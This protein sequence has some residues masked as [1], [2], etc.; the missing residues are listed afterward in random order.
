MKRILGEDSNVGVMGY[1]GKDAFSQFF[2]DG[3]DSMGINTYGLMDWA[4]IPIGISIMTKG[5][6]ERSGIAYFYRANGF[7]DGKDE[8]KKRMIFLNPRI[9][10]NS[11]IG[12][13]PTGWDMDNGRNAERFLKW[14]QHDL[15]AITTTDTHTFGRKQQ[16]VNREKI[17]EYNLLQHPLAYTNIFICSL[18]EAKRIMNTWGIGYDETAEP[19]DIAYQFLEELTETYFEQEMKTSTLPRIFGVS[20]REGVL[21]RYQ[22]NSGKIHDPVYVPSNYSQIKGV[23]LVGAGDSLKASLGAYISQNWGAFKEHKGE[24]NVKEAAQFAQLGATIYVT[25]PEDKKGVARFENIPT[26]NPMLEVIR[27]GEQFSKLKK[28]QKALTN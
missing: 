24:F 21:L 3:M 9:C 20:M 4:N 16:V 6:G 18:A 25:T 10:H 7:F 19:K 14:Q 26:Y 13:S 12:L 28:L 1:L 22:D 23:D 5:K 17:E 27:S 11:Y 15:G 8:V 2:R